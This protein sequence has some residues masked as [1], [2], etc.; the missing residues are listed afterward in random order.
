MIPAEAKSINGSHTVEAYHSLGLQTLQDETLGDV[1]IGSPAYAAGL[2]PGDK[3][4]TV[5]GAPYTAEALVSAIHEA[6]TD[7]GPIIVTASRD[8]ETQT[9]R[10]EYHGGEKYAA[11]VRNEKPDLLTTAILRPR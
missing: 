8:D 4:I 2:G 3:L 10:I 6:T 1:W 5:N 11:L 9:Y 7:A